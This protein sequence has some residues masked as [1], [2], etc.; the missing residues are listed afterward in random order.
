ML[1]TA[2]KAVFHYS[3]LLSLSRAF[4]QARVP[5]LRYH[6]V[7]DP[8]DRADLYLAESLSISSE[9][10]EKQVR[11]LARHFSIVP[12]EDLVQRLR[13]G[14]PPYRN[15]L[16]ITF[17]DGYRDNY[18]RAFPILQRY[19]APATFYLT[20]GCIE[21]K[22]ILWTARLRYMLTVSQVRQLTL[23]HP[24]V[25]TFQLPEAREEAFRTL[26]VYMKNI[27]T[28]ARLELLDSVGTQLE[29][30]DLSPLQQMMMSWD[31]M[32]EMR[33]GGMSF[34]AH[35]VTH[36]NLP[37][38]LPE[39]AEQEIRISREVLEGQLNEPVLHFAYPNGRGSSHLTEQVKACVQ[40][41]GFHSAVTSLWGCVQPGDDLFALRRV[42]VYRK[43]GSIPAL[44]LDIERNRWQG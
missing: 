43:H 22:Q 29:V 19:Q 3:G 35:T 21:N 42:G 4:A 23:T 2:L 9:D 20:T 15:A 37:N 30:T 26:V 11:F 44:S 41:A 31:E 8:E 36:P 24:K 38:A 39:E 12:L 10:F 25:E 27:S 1:S 16:A 33:R 32:R 5:V 14:K 7:A 18:L 17:D 28:Q 13:Q 34:G 6:S 40:S